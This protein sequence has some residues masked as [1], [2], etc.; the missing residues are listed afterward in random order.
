MKTTTASK[1][2]FLALTQA[3]CAQCV[4]LQEEIR[5]LR[6]EN[7]RL[8]ARLGY[9]QRQIDEGISARPRR[10]PRNLSKPPPKLRPTTVVH[11]KAIVGMAA[12]PLPKN[13]PTR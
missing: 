8:K 2:R 5:R 11:V 7:R 3:I 13:K 4:K 9:Q 1:N 6:D 10:L 12:R